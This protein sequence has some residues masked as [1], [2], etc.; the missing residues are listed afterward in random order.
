MTS[1]PPRHDPI[2]VCSWSLQPKSPD[3]LIASLDRLGLRRVQL[4]LNPLMHDPDRWRGAIDQLR[5]AGIKI[6][7]GMMEA[8]GEDYST[9]ESIARTGG[10]RPDETWEVNRRHA[11]Q[12]AELAG[13]NGI[14]LITFHAGFLPHDPDSPERATLLSRLRT[15]AEVFGRHEISVALETGQETA[16]T[17]EGVL[18]DLN[19]ASIGVNFD[20]ANMILYGMGDPVESFQRLAPWVRQVHIKDAVP[21]ESPGTWGAE[22][23]AGTGAVDWAAFLKLARG[24]EPPVDL[25]IERESGHDRELDIAAAAAMVRRLLD[26]RR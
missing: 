4:A 18:A 25:V 16:E 24:L 15:I 2:A 19:M 1:H 21:C 8:A 20:P 11:E 14:A 12:V 5:T 7:S 26:E 10:L 17:L 22:V 3:D 9:L 23:P 13:S 6:V